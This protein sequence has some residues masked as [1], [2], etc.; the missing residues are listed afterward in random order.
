MHVRH[1]R[2]ATGSP[3]HVRER[4]IERVLADS[5]VSRKVATS[6]AGVGELVAPILKT[7]HRFMF[8]MCAYQI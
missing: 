2:D 6:A 3:V 4:L 8:I 7:S 5:L 1:I